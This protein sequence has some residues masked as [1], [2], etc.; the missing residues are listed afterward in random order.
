MEGEGVRDIRQKWRDKVSFTLG[1]ERFRQGGSIRD[2]VRRVEVLEKRYE[3][4]K[5]SEKRTDNKD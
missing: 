1:R 3:K 2:R 4:K 5:E